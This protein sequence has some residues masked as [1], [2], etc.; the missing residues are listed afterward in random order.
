[1]IGTSQVF[2]IVTQQL[3]PIVQKTVSENR[4]TTARTEQISIIM[5]SNIKSVLASSSSGKKI[6]ET[7]VPYS[8][9]PAP[10]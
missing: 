2:T 4:L 5:T 6:G 8:F 10:F 7:S 1:M 9:P 3:S